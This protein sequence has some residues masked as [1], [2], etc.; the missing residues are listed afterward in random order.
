LDV[1]HTKTTTADYTDFDIY[2]SA[3]SSDD[4]NSAINDKFDNCI[5]SQ[6]NA[7]A[8]VS[9]A[10]EKLTYDKETG[11]Y[12]VKGTFHSSDFGVD[13]DIEA[14]FGLDANLMLTSFD[15]SYATTAGT[16]TTTTQVS[17]SNLGKEAVTEY[18]DTFCLSNIAVVTC[19][20]KGTFI[21]RYYCVKGESIQHFGQIVASGVY[22]GVN[23]N[24]YYTVSANLTGDLTGDVT[25]ETVDS[26]IYESAISIPESGDVTIPSS[27]TF[28]G[29]YAF[30]GK[31]LNSLTVGKGTTLGNYSLF[32]VT[33][34]KTL[35][36]DME[37]I[38]NIEG[39][40]GGDCPSLQ[41]I[42]IGPDT[43]NID[44]GVFAGLSGLTAIN[45][46]AA[47]TTYSSSDG[48]LMSKDGT[49]IY[50]VPAGKFTESQSYTIPDNV[51]Y[52][53]KDSF[54]NVSLKTVIIPAA[55]I[56]ISSEAF[57][58]SKVGI[59]VV[60]PANPSFY[61][62][63]DGSL[64]FK[65]SINSESKVALYKVPCTRAGAFA[66]PDDVNFVYTPFKGC[67]GITSVTIGSKVEN[68]Y[69]DTFEGC[70]DNVEVTLSS[71]NTNLKMEDGAIYTSDGSALLYIS[72]TKTGTYTLPASVTDIFSY[73]EELII[74]LFAA[75][76]ITAIE[77]AE[78]NTAF[79]SYD[80]A[81]YD[82]AQ[83]KLV[84]IPV[85]K[86]GSITI[87]STVTSGL[88]PQKFKGYGNQLKLTA[89]NV[90]PA[91]TSFVS[92][93]GVLCSLQGGGIIAYPLGKEGPYTFVS[94]YDHPSESD[95]FQGADKLTYLIVNCLPDC[96]FTDM[97]SLTAIYYDPGDEPD[98]GY[99]DY[100]SKG[101][102]STVTLYAFTNK[103]PTAK[104]LAVYT[105]YYH[106]VNGVPTAWAVA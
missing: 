93:D 53:F 96:E 54:K 34:L 1:T 55:T 81:L 83:T 90:D 32:N 73:R 23:V 106:L 88:Y 43:T 25:F 13:V 44:Q 76:G 69:A 64:Y 45:V 82:K 70:A 63:S 3:D 27:I 95:V 66:I 85:G 39:I 99:V 77:V 72:K 40:F 74:Y 103:A 37:D 78:G 52:I 2:S 19:N 68:I 80:G 75:K 21:N 8:F 11:M 10:Y 22:D 35:S 105:H 67:S 98:L 18:N 31:S 9:T 87:P 48:I 46:D 97:A 41:T 62:G 104:Q 28:V 4:Y 17:I 15:C 36:I 61:S 57:D 47:N 91:N 60:D 26:C 16:E 89:I 51:T 71:S 86:T 38:Q 24:C 56:S 20:Y 49:K 100:Y 84:A 30:Y 59:F 92:V 42:N 101:L 65:F 102:P 33:G 29:D 12:E 50:A 58:N 7:S 94:P 6:V 5:S 79:S 14:H